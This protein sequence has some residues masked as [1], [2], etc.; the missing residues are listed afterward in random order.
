MHGWLKTGY[1]LGLHG[2]MASKIGLKIEKFPV[3]F[4]V[5]GN[6]LRRVGSRLRPPPRI[7]QRRPFRGV[8]VFW[9]IP[10]RLT[11]RR[12]LAIYYAKVSME[13]PPLGRILSPGITVAPTSCRRRFATNF[14]RWYLVQHISGYQDSAYYPSVLPFPYFRS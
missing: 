6:L 8:F 14:H 7:K 13:K 2:G 5:N 12:L 10:Q 1:V 4:P 9:P 3:N 11:D